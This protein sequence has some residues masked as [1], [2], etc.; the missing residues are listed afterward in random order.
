MIRAIRVIREMKMKKLN[1]WDLLA[2][3]AYV[4]LIVYFLLKVLG[5][6]HSPPTIDVA[7]IASS[8]YYVG[9]YTHK[10]DSIDRRLEDHIKDKNLHK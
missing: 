4:Y 9:R 5:F 7:A 1:F 8:A 2:W 10:I 6:L 3:L